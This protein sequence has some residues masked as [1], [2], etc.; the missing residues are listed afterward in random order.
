MFFLNWFEVHLW[1][2]WSAVLSLILFFCSRCT[3]S[4]LEHLWRVL[5]S[6][7]FLTRL[8]FSKL[9]LRDILKDVSSCSLHFGVL[10][11]SA[12]NITFSESIL[13]DIFEDCNQLCFSRCTTPSGRRYVVN[14]SITFSKLTFS[15]LSEQK[16]YKRCHW[17]STFS[18]GTR[19]HLLGILMCQ[20]EPFRYKDVP[21]ENQRLGFECEV[22]EGCG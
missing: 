20:N 17:C 1:K 4:L 10:M 18:K 22:S 13:S 5:T 14:Q 6:F 7:M 8:T 3:T 15:A 9:T 12:K 11:Q 16:R 21:S 19:L 2:L